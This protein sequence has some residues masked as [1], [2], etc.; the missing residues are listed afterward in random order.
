MFVLDKLVGV[1]NSAM[2][3]CVTT[4]VFVG[5]GGAGV[6]VGVAVKNQAVGVK[7]G[8][9]VGVARAVG[10]GVKIM[11]AKSGACTVTIAPRKVQRAQLRMIILK[12]SGRQ[13][14]EGCWFILEMVTIN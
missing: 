3:L 7:V 5:V 10:V 13:S 12:A 14:H 9:R 1:A 6:P 4:R 8:T 2:L 11:A